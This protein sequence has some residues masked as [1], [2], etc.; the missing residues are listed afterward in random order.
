LSSV[1]L[2]VYDF[3]ER[4]V[5]AYRKAGF[6]EIGRRRGVRHGARMVQEVIMDI[7][8]GEVAGLTD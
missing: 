8:P 4:A 2:N 5:A 1:I 3:N 7:V 6:H